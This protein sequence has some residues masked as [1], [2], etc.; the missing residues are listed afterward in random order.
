MGHSTCSIDGCEGRHEA[1]GWC[2]TH[3]GRWRRHGDPL[4]LDP[5]A[6]LRMLGADE[7][8]LAQVDRL[9]SGCWRWTGAEHG[10]GYGLFKDRGKSHMAHRW[11]YA[12]WKGVP[13]AGLH[14]DHYRFPQD[15]CLGPPCVNPD[16][17]RPATPRENT[18]RG[19]SVGAA[20]LAKT[21]CPQGH[22]YAGEN[23]RIARTGCRIC[24]TCSRRAMM[25]RYYR[26]KAL[27]S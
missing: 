11:A 14:L 8:F 20:N 27:R 23:L 25:A 10:Q 17:V 12:R 5:G 2:V 9:P 19:D 16:H 22:P 24:R 4:Y 13:A 21:H 18:L 15:G 26:K 3:Y 1:R 7:R 6:R